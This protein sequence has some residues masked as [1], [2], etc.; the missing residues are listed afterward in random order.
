MPGNLPLTGLLLMG[1]LLMGPLLM[2]PL[3][4]GP[5]IGVRLRTLYNRHWRP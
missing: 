5:L 1:S 2:G 3:L 4:M